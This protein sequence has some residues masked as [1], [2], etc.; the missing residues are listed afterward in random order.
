[1]ACMWAAI[2]ALRARVPV[3]TLIAARVLQARMLA[4][5][6]RAHIRAAA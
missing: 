1:M 5:E 4:R 6:Q 3:G 2:G